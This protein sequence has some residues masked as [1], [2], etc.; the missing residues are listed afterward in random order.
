MSG[1]CLSIF[2]MCGWCCIV[3]AILLSKA[4]DV[5]FLLWTGIVW[6]FG[7]LAV[8]AFI[9]YFKAKGLWKYF[10]ELNAKLNPRGVNWIMSS[11]EV[12]IHLNVAYI[13]P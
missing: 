3:I 10:N 7:G 12:Y 11:S 1:P 8:I 4:N 6:T 9:G 2:P 13:K 5:D